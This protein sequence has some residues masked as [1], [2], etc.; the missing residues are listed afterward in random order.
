MLRYAFVFCLFVF[1][2]RFSLVFFSFISLLFRDSRGRISLPA[3]KNLFVSF[4]LEKKNERKKN[5][6]FF[7]LFF[8]VSLKE[9]TGDFGP[10]TWLLKA[11]GR[12]FFFFFPF[13]LFFFFGCET[14]ISLLPG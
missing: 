2:C 6:F 4:I 5:L 7:P 12:L 1:F 8:S 13:F 10:D 11:I 14:F 3:H 9:R